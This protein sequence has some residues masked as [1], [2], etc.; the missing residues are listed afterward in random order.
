M[1]DG[2]AGSS[3][4]SMRTGDTASV[5][6]TGSGGSGAG[7]PAYTRGPKTRRVRNG[8][9]S[10]TGVGGDDVSLSS[11]SLADHR[12]SS[13]SSFEHP[14]V[15]FSHDSGVSIYSKWSGDDRSVRSMGSSHDM[16]EEELGGISAGD[17]G[18]SSRHYGVNHQGFISSP[19]V[20]G[21]S[22]TRR[23]H[24]SPS[25]Q[26]TPADFSSSGGTGLR[27]TMGGRTPSVH[28]L[29][30]DAGVGGSNC[31][32]SGGG[33][34]RGERTD[35][36]LPLPHTL[37]HS[38]HSHTPLHHQQQHSPS[39]QQQ[40]SLPPPMFLAHSNW[41]PDTDYGRRLLEGHHGLGGQ[42]NNSSNASSPASSGWT[43]P[44]GQPESQRQH[45]GDAMD[46]D[47]EEAASGSYR[48]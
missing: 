22:V 26:S 41:T 4:S 31:G 1:P 8:N 10:V 21:A 18:Q 28:S 19:S 33:A 24:R 9:G 5:R 39:Q 12:L 15:R 48:Y 16:A 35:F 45:G 37:S 42:S 23:V 32:I 47:S 11:A 17:G 34:G 43:G 13:V 30:I 36:I 40:S 29:P 20:G 14:D 38:H 3:A 44:T 2:P 46:V 25:I 7:A 6:S 27:R